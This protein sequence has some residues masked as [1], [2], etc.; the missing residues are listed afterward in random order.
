MR[1]PRFERR[2]AEESKRGSHRIVAGSLPYG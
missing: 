2:L 1:W